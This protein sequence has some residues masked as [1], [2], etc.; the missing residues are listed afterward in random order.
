MT[1]TTMPTVAPRTVWRVTVGFTYLREACRKTG[2]DPNA[3]V[4]EQIQPRHKADAAEAY[5]EFPTYFCDTRH[6]FVLL[7]AQLVRRN[8]P[9]EVSLRQIAPKTEELISFARIYPRMDDE[10]RRLL[11]QIDP[12]MAHTMA[13]L[14][15]RIETV[16]ERLRRKLAGGV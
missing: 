9:L 11:M 16:F 10:I 3:V 1:Q 15:A 2:I 6:K 14:N 7:L 5:L 8:L 12:Q 4:V 13:D